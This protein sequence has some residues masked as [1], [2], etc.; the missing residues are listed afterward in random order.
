MS[1][2]YGITETDCLIYVS[3]DGLGS[4]PVSWTSGQSICAVLSDWSIKDA[5]EGKQVFT[6]GSR[7]ARGDYPGHLETTFSFGALHTT[8]TFGQAGA[9]KMLR[10]LCKAG[11][12]FALHMKVGNLGGTPHD[13]IT[14]IRCKATNSE[15]KAD[16]AGGITV[17]MDGF[18]TH[19]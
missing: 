13:T 17:S 18:A 4:A 15:I 9:T 19:V 5:D 8:D 3:T 7:Y 12:R 11:T 2:Y 14:L 1:Q 10:E 6:A 16:E